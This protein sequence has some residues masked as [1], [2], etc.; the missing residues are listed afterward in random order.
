MFDGIDYSLWPILVILVVY[1]RR[2]WFLPLFFFTRIP[3]N[4]FTL[5]SVNRGQ[6][7]I[8]FYCWLSTV[9]GVLFVR[10]AAKV[11]I[12][13]TIGTPEFLELWFRWFTHFYRVLWI[14]QCSST[15]QVRS[16]FA[17]HFLFPFK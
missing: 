2:C 15:N 17:D 8:S 6:I 13:Y 9:V 12:C 10:T 3:I 4:G 16:S 1:S 5:T 14:A 7:I 11:F